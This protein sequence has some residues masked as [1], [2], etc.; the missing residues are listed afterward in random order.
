MGQGGYQTTYSFERELPESCEDH[1]MLDQPEVI[2]I[3]TD[4]SG[5]KESQ[6]LAN[7]IEQR[8][9]FSTQAYM[10]IYIREDESDE[11]LKEPKLE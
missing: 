9:A 10:L 5:E 6:N 1:A 4:A 3:T 8:K 7:L 11:I 2:E